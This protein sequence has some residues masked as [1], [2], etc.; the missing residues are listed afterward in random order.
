MIT[1]LGYNVS[2]EDY[3]PLEKRV[4]QLQDCPPPK[5]INQLPR[6]LRMLNFYRRFLPEAAVTQAPLHDV[7]SGPRVKGSH[8]IAWTPELHR[9]FGE[10]TA[11][12]DHVGVNNGRLHT[13]YLYNTSQRFSIVQSSAT[14]HQFSAVQWVLR[15]HFHLIGSLKIS[16]FL[17]TFHFGEQVSYWGLNSVNVGSV[18]LL[19]CTYGLKLLQGEDV[20]SPSIVFM[21]NPLLVFPQFLSLHPHTISELGQ[22]FEVALYINCLI[23]RYP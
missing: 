11:S 12:L 14:G 21:Q 9:A 19:E 17:L 3:R 22:N 5:T 18:R 20:V 6:F 2:A 23:L 15:F 4:A 8:P 16:S 10:C 13:L 7:L 1:F